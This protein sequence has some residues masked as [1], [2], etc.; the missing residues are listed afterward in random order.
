MNKIFTISLVL[1]LLLV[2][3]VSAYICIDRQSD[4]IAVQEFKSDLNKIS[5]L[6]DFENGLTP[7]AINLKLKY[8]GPCNK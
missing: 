8:F 6:E 2:G 4:N 1:G 3:S 7:E 5:L